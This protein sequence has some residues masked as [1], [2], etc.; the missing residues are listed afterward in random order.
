M[1]T[2]V[3][4]P[5]LVPAMLC[6][7]ASTALAQNGIDISAAAFGAQITTTGSDAIRIL[8]AGDDGIQIGTGTTYPNYG[9]YIPSPG[10]PNYGLWPN[11]ANAQ[12]N[13][14]LFTVDNISVG[15]L[16]ARSQALIAQVGAGEALVAGDVVAATGVAPAA[17][18]ESVATVVVR[19]SGTGSDGVVGVVHSRL[20]WV[21]PMGK[22]GEQALE[23]AE[24]PAQ[25]GDLVAITV[26]GVA[27]ASI[28]PGTAIV[29][30][31]RLV[32]ASSPGTARPM[33]TRRIDGFEVAEGRPAIG[34]ALEASAGDE[35]SLLVFVGQR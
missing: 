16:T 34:V 18:D 10:V 29:A 25:P 24:G 23:A 2:I 32:A 9:V 12:G 3:L 31:Q 4:S 19:R 7:G 33:R 20:Q 6:L 30:G 13:W 5:L 28:E 35:P 26:L 17:I 8:D 27:R 22:D 21:Q 14:A 1:R 15:N 11:T